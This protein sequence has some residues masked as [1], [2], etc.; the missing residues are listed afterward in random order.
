MWVIWVYI[1]FIVFMK[2]LLISY[3]SFFLLS[4]DLFLEFINYGVLGSYY[5][6]VRVDIYCYV[7]FIR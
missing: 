6:L 4:L 7:L 3:S 5:Y 1:F 2:L